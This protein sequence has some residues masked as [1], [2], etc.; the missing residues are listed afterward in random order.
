MAAR[1]YP[2]APLKTDKMPPGIPFIINNEA[3]E[4]FCFYGMNTILTVFM[5][6]YLLGA[7]GALQTM[8]G[9]QAKERFHL[10]IFAVY[11][12][13][14]LG[15]IISDALWG[16]YRTIIRLSL[17]YCL[18]CLALSANQTRLGLGIGLTL[19]AVGSGGIKPCVSALLGD[20]FGATNQ[21][22]LSKAYGWFY[23]SVNVG[24]FFS[25]LLTPWLLEKYGP[26]WAFG[27]PAALMFLATVIM[28]LG[29]YR[30]VRIAPAGM[31]FV[32]EILAEDGLRL[33]LRLSGVFITVSMFWA[34]W[35]Q[36]GSA[37]VLQAEKMDRHV[38]GVELLPSQI[39]A[40]NPL[41]ILIFIPFFS[42]V[43]YPLIDRIFVLTALRKISIGLFLTVPTFLIPAW[44]ES[45]I[46][47]GLSPSIAWQI[48]DY[49]IL[50]AAEI[51]VS[52]SCLEFFYTQ[53][54]KRM[55]SLTTSFYLFSIALGNGFTS[56]IN[57][58]IQ[59]PDGSSKLA[60]A[61]YYL[62]F[63]GCMFLTA[64]VFIFVAMF[65]RG[66]VHIQD[67]AEATA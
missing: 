3:A 52:I 9:D 48:L 58:V 14:L 22:L 35:N 5:T 21:H 34:L 7:N 17:V 32:R 44:V 56:F 19:I 59:N 57:H 66:Q 25:T 36:T 38:F 16:K 65:Y 43:V 51:M 26:R 11:F 67:E 20:Q 29:R 42:Y 30:Y 8:T 4:R 60:G 23:F 49:V 53:G 6:Q 28:W 40:A 50:T 47:H 61:N 13:P 41:L 31:G 63:A 12:F 45:Q 24:S 62:F 18:G 54:P 46:G 27:V 15:A 2:T 10:F 1:S 55:K 33:I 39:Q 64:V 37:F